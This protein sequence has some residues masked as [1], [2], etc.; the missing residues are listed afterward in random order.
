MALGVRDSGHTDM[1]TMARNTLASVSATFPSQPWQRQLLCFR[2]KRGRP[3]AE[4][5]A[6]HWAGPS[7]QAPAAINT[8]PVDRCLQA[9]RRGRVRH[10][11][12]S[13]DHRSTRVTCARPG[14]RASVRRWLRRPSKPRTYDAQP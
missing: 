10:E 14:H 9:C 11:A 1:A 3:E 7:R 13:G 5:Q 4:P 6:A 12:L 8:R 2:G